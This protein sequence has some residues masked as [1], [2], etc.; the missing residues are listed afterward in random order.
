MTEG[1]CARGREMKRG[2]KLLKRREGCRERERWGR[3][4]WDGGGRREPGVTLT[5]VVSC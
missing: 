3:W 1:I 4:W 2:R 5:A